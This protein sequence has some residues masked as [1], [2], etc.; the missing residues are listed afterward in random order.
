MIALMQKMQKSVL[1][2][3]SGG[4]DSS[5]AA[6]LLHNQGYRV[7]G[8][9]MKLWDYEQVGG[10][11]NT[12]SGCCSLESIHDAK[13]VCAQYDIP[14]YVFNF[15]REF[16]ERVID[17]F[18]HEYLTGRTPNPCI[19]CNTFIKWQTFQE[20]A[21]EIGVDFISTGHYAL[22]VFNEHSGRYELHRGKD[23]VKDQSYALWGLSQENLAK[24]LFPLGSLSKE[25][26]RTIAREYHLPIAEKRESQEICFIPDNNYHRLL[27]IMRPYLEH[28]IVEGD[29]IDME[30]NVIGR[31]PGFPFYTIGQRK[32]LG[33][34]YPE[35]KYVV[36]I[37]ARKNQIMIGDK[38]ALAGEA[39][40]AEKVNLIS[41]KNLTDPIDVEIKIR[42]NDHG[43]SATVYP[44]EE[45]KV[46]VI[47]KRPQLAITPGQSA[48]FFDGTKVIGG[49]VIT[50]QIDAR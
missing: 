43:H 37:N 33:G 46:K 12:E 29:I 2:A 8:A 18:M 7:I 19:R 23:S 44:E 9:T 6:I 39:F 34:G 36:G 47:F 42:Y 32:G 16:H 27:K 17:N 41:L 3:M 28:E 26:V 31:H 22:I 50:K 35:P 38:K 45:K 11:I 1:V 14:H 13:K 20:K 48:V 25:K 10:A 49:G 5:V 15:S 40:L 4:V 24:T 30:G 21:Q